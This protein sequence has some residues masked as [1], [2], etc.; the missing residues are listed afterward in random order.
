MNFAVGL[1]SRRALAVSVTTISVLGFALAQAPPVVDG[2]PLAGH[3]KAVVAISWSADGQTI[4]SSSLDGTV[5]VWDVVARQEIGKG[6]TSSLP[7]NR[8]L[9]VAANP[10]PSSSAVLSG[11][12]EGVKLWIRPGAAI[13]KNLITSAITA[14]AVHQDAKSSK[15]A[16]AVG[17]DV[18]IWDLAASTPASTG[19]ISHDGDATAI[20][21]SGDG[22]TIASG[23]GGE[24]RVSDASGKLQGRRLKVNS[25]TTG[26][27][28][29]PTNNNM[30]VSVHDDGLGRVWDLSSAKGVSKVGASP[31]ITSV[32]ICTNAVRFATW[33]G[34]TI[35]FWKGDGTKDTASFTPTASISA[36]AVSHD[37]L[38]VAYILSTD[39]SLNYED[40]KKHVIAKSVPNAAVLVIRLDRSA[41]KGAAVVADTKGRISQF[42]IDMTKDNDDVTPA[43][44]V[45]AGA[46]VS[47][48]AFH[49]T[50]GDRVFFADPKKD[51]VSQVDATTKTIVNS[52]AVT[53]GSQVRSLCLSTDGRG[54]S[55]LAIGT[56]KQDLK[57]YSNLDAAIPVA[58]FEVSAQAAVISVGLSPD[59]KKL[60]GTTDDGTVVSWDVASKAALEIFPRDPPGGAATLLATG[61]NDTGA[62]SLWSDGVRAWTLAATG[63]L[64]PGS[65]RSAKSV[66]AGTDSAGNNQ[67]VVG[68]ADGA[69]SFRLDGASSPVAPTGTSSAVNAVVFTPDKTF[70]VGS[71]DHGIYT[72]DAVAPALTKSFDAMQKVAALA[73]DPDNKSRIL[74]GLGNAT[75]QVID[76]DKAM[77]VQ[78]VNL[79]GDEVKAVAFV[80][81]IAPP[82]KATLAIGTKSSLGVW[83][84]V[85]SAMV[86]VTVFQQGGRIQG[87]AWLPP[88]KAGSRSKEFVAGGVTAAAPKTAGAPVDFV[89][90]VVFGNVDPTIL[91][92]KKLLDVTQP[93]SAVAAHPSKDLTATAAKTVIQF[94]TKD[95]N[96]A[97]AP[98]SIKKH[99]GTVNA[100]AYS[101]DGT[102]LAS[103]STD[104]SLRLWKAD[105]GTEMPQRLDATATP[106][107]I[108][109]VEF[110]PDSARIAAV[111]DKGNLTIWNVASG[112]VTGTAAVSAKRAT[113]VAWKPD[114]KQ[115]AVGSEDT[116]IFIFKG[117]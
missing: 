78:T 96:P 41:S 103:G 95:G 105:D 51:S 81:D 57:V 62:F 74:A 39:Q 16:A 76:L 5:R 9:S 20:A 2:P 89:G 73:I 61:L 84:R 13:N 117:L 79:N 26:L 55:R 19:K 34:T 31:A 18:Q 7:T 60:L 38:A 113:S 101:P 111:D 94:W 114:G 40:A 35:Q 90:T 14:L 86:A 10:D 109:G 50:N 28:Y 87:V 32:A 49:P 52:F 46:P 11:D 25:K 33:D 17:K 58:D 63:V 66:A 47:A 68:Y 85:D 4:V 70:L 12:F 15:L 44:L 75:A 104:T 54:A 69:A 30:L 45:D 77:A 116:T 100:L 92:T 112:K 93:I 36:F 65:S 37:G 29:L 8:V 24:I 21:W 88:A 1:C 67:A 80:P 6:N 43:P 106:A 64:D 107:S 102:I 110:S 27:A 99:S 115:L 97:S 91:P 53:K 71:D 22:S 42:A 59:G 72:W 82:E 56:D 48:L 108:L 83:S 3:S 23:D 98:S